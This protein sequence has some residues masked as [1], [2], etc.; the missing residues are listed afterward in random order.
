ME[1][2]TFGHPLIA[3]SELC[4]LPSK[5]TAVPYFCVTFHVVMKAMF[6]PTNINVLLANG[7][8]NLDVMRQK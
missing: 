6:V 8:V 5:K 7:I 1:N 4:S 2:E 3:V